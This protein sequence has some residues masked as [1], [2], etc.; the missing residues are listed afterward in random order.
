TLAQ[1]QEIFRQQA[2]LHP[3]PAY[4]TYRWGKD[5]QIWLIEARDYRSP[6]EAPDSPE[7]TIWGLEQKAWFKKTVTESD[8]TWKLLISPTPMI[9]PDRPHKKDNHSNAAFQHEG[10]E[11]RGWFSK[12]LP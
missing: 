2:P 9:G 3:G 1:G 8:A 10:D 4:R 6:Y 11:L 12:H 7:K 5:L